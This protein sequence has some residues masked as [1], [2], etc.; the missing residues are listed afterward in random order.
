MH[1]QRAEGRDSLDDAGEPDPTQALIKTQYMVAQSPV[2]AVAE[3]DD[4]G[5]VAGGEEAHRHRFP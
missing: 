5:T 4:Q 2:D 1:H 3:L